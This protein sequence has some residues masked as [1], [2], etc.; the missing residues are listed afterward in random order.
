VQAGRLDG[1][2]VEA[3]L[4]AA[5]QHARRRLGWPAGLTDREVTVL[6]LL[7][8]GR[9]PAQIATAL[10][11]SPKTVRNHVEHIYAK[12]GASNRTGAALFAVAHGLLGATPEDEP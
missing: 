11:I 10:S 5:G 1:P 6:R 2:A 3:V 9:S 12:I 8:Q 4:A 7:A